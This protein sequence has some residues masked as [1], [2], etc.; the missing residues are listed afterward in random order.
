[1]SKSEYYWGYRSFTGWLLLLLFVISFVSSVWASCPKCSPGGT[2]QNAFCNQC[3]KRFTEASGQ[4]ASALQSAIQDGKN[5]PPEATGGQMLTQLATVITASIQNNQE[6]KTEVNSWM[7][8]LQRTYQGHFGDPSS[9]QGVLHSYSLL[10]EHQ[11]WQILNILAAIQKPVHLPLNMGRLIHAAALARA[12]IAVHSPR[13]SMAQDKVF[14]QLTLGYYLYPYIAEAGG[15][16]WTTSPT[17]L[18]YLSYLQRVLFEQAGYMN[19]HHSDQNVMVLDGASPYPQFTVEAAGMTQAGEVWQDVHAQRRKF[20]AEHNNNVCT[21][22]LNVN[23]SAVASELISF[24]D[25]YTEQNM[26]LNF[27]HGGT[28][29]DNLVLIPIEPDS[30]DLQYMVI[31]PAHLLVITVEHQQLHDFV[32][33]LIDGLTQTGQYLHPTLLVRLLRYT[34]RTLRSADTPL[35]R[36]ETYSFFGGT[37][38]M[39]FVLSQLVA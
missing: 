17:N 3:N 5:L 15:A 35:R 23:Q 11:L 22:N 6:V 10:T 32:P 38:G 39:F 7:F 25:G 20:W 13:S 27:V 12:W 8:Y 21:L 30:G 18:Y 34:R 1:M 26:Q 14:I 9:I 33:G 36:L 2:Y 28:L 29:V 19:F 24:L 4:V 16:P 37:G 31:M